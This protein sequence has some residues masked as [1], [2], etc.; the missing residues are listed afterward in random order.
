MAKLSYGSVYFRGV[1]GY[2]V[3]EYQDP[4]SR[5]SRI[6]KLI[7][8]DGYGICSP[9]PGNERKAIRLA[10]PIAEELQSTIRLKS[11]EEL[12]IR[13]AQQ[14]RLLTLLK[15]PIG[16]VWNS[17][18]NHPNRNA[19]SPNTV[20]NYYNYWN[21]FLQWLGDH[22]QEVKS[23]HQLDRSMATEYFTFRW[24]TGISEQGYNNNLQALQVIMKTL[25]GEDSPDMQ[26]PFMGLRKKKT[27]VH[28]RLPFTPDEVKRILEL[29]EDGNPFEMEYKPQFRLLVKLMLN[30]G[31]RGED[32][33]HLTWRMV[34]WEE[35]LIRYRPIKTEISSGIDVEAPINNILFAELQVAQGYAVDSFV[36]PD[37]H[38]RYVGNPTGIT[39]SI[40]RLIDAAGIERCIPAGNIR[41]Q[42]YTKQELKNG[43]PVE[44]QAQKKIALK[45][46]HSFRHTFVT[47]AAA[48]GV[49]LRTIQDMAGHTTGL[50]TLHYA[51]SS[52]NRKREAVAKLGNAYS[53]ISGNGT[54][55]TLEK[56]LAILTPEQL[57][58]LKAR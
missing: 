13:I 22:H 38:R 14:R 30:I 33:C 51:H 45:T 21:A 49:E 34:D 56:V 26:N 37:L 11:N 29:L 7:D 48:N 41:R 42:F 36:L 3:Y 39:H 20:R 18:H 52:R 50:M 8:E 16:D 53:G 6:R 55:A 24:S 4:V 44:V 31:C 28:S 2:Y 54:E 57:E 32:A 46:M 19:K 9:S 27:A 40:N 12:L 1:K 15:M 10:I 25:L 58:L 35:R 23:A 5:K 47:T 43:V 17:Y